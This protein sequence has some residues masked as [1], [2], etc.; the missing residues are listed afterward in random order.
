VS[1]KDISD[2]RAFPLGCRLIHSIHG[3]GEFG[4]DEA[5]I[6]IRGGIRQ[7]QHDTRSQD[8][9]CQ[10]KTQE[11]HTSP[12]IDAYCEPVSRQSDWKPSSEQDE[13]LQDSS[14]ALDGPQ[15]SRFDCVSLC[16][17]DQSSPHERKKCMG[18]AVPFDLAS[19]PTLMLFVLFLHRHIRSSLIG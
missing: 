13:R 12:Q 5:Q 18:L 14:N 17:D 4:L 2:H 15:L 1:S 11:T 9:N 19:L 7:C 6:L 10:D 16:L 3:L 8:H